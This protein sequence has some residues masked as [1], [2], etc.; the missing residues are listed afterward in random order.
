MAKAFK[1][2]VIKYHKEISKIFAALKEVKSNLPNIGI[3]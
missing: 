2:N 1:S 3:K